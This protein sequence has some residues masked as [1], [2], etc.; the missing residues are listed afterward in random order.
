MKIEK[1]VAIVGDMPP[2]VNKRSER[3]KYRVVAVALDKKGRVLSMRANDYKCTHPLQK[4]FAEQAGSPESIFLHAEIA[5][6]IAAK[7]EVHT[8]LVA[9]VDSKGNPVSAKP[10]PICSKA[11]EAFGVKNVIHT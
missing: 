3:R 5:T 6:L 4:Y 2:L 7:K 8:L 11:I 10:C 1:L 9:R